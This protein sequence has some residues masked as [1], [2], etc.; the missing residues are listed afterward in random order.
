MRLKNP[1]VSRKEISK[2]MTIKKGEV[3]QYLTTFYDLMEE[4]LVVLG[5]IMSFSKYKAIQ[6]LGMSLMPG[7]NFW[8][9]ELWLTAM[10]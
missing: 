6:F 8:G 1:L 7:A 2:Y 5:M 4:D 3:G 10:I 9:A